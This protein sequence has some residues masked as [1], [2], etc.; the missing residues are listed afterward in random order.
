MS[1]TKRMHWLLATPDDFD[2][3]TDHHNLVFI[4]DPHTVV[5]DLSQLSLRKV[6]R[7]AI[8]LSAYNYPCV[9]ITGRR[10]RLG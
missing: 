9:H 8:R 10:Q 6:L 5:T 3:F 7:W 2:Y 4:F 1:T